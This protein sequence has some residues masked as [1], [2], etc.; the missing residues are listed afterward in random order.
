LRIALARGSGWVLNS[1]G[2]ARLRNLCISD[3]CRTDVDNW[4]RESTEPVSVGISGVDP[5]SYSVQ[6]GR[7]YLRSREELAAK[8]AQFPA[9]TRFA[10]GYRPGPNSRADLIEEAQRIEALVPGLR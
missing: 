8:V 2:M 5:E 1:E 4:N 7:F 6:V 10:W 9:G 3:W